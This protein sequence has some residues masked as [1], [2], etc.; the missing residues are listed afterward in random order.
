MIFRRADE[1]DLLEL[2]RIEEECFGAERFSTEIVRAFIVRA[3]AF[4]V[5]AEDE[6]MGRLVGSA[7]CLISENTGEGRIA[8]IAVI[9]DR[10]KQGVGSG[11]LA[12]CERILNTF[13]LRKYVL[14]VET[15]NMPAILMYTHREYEVVGLLKDYYG[16]GRDAYSMERKMS[17]G[18]R[19]L[20]VEQG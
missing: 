14:E 11:L 18:S 16:L 3:D 4:T 13:R 19:R 12:E 5:V 9:N 15:S 6:R 17:G 7:S 8:S 2:L 20:T 1:N 10:R